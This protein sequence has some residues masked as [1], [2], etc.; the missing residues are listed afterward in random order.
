MHL[1][2]PASPCTKWPPTCPTCPTRHLTPNRTA[3][4]ACPPACLQ[5]LIPSSIPLPAPGASCTHT[6]DDGESLF[7]LAGRYST[8]LDDLLD[9]NPELQ[10]DPNSLQPGTIITV[11]PNC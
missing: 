3:V 7:E 4:A 1:C 2:I 9:L 10:D 5:V 6:A 8:T 11:F